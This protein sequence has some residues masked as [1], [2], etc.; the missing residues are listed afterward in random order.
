[1]LFGAEP[2]SLTQA[3]F[4]CKGAAGRSVSHEGKEYGDCAGGH[5]PLGGVRRDL[6]TL[7]NRFQ[8]QTGRALTV[9]SG[10]RCQAH[11]RYSWAFVR[12]RGER[13]DAVSRQ[14]L[15]RAGAAADFYVDGVSNQEQYGKWA[16]ELVRLAGDLGLKAWTRVY[17]AQEGRDPDNLHAFPYIHLHL[18]GVKREA[19]P[20]GKPAKDV[21]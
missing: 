5:G 6:L 10:Y 13:E 3:D 2:R 17:G 14:S 21:Q 18:L 12:S 8:S 15:H 19:L 16:E 4:R 7:L 11:N 9:S 20:P 1:M